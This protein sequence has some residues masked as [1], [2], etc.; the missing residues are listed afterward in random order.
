MTEDRISRICS[1]ENCNRQHNCKGYCRKHY[2]RWQKYGN[3][4]ITLTHVAEGDTLAERF[5]S[6]VE[7]T[8]DNN[9]CWNWKGFPTR[10]WHPSFTY[11]GRKQVV[12]RWAWF[13]TYGNDATMNLLHSCDN[14]RCVNP[15]HLREGTHQENMRDKQ[16]RGRQPKGEAI[17]TAQIV[18][19]DVRDIRLRLQTGIGVSAL[20]RQ[21]NISRDI[22]SDISLGRTWR[23]VT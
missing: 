2:H 23:H 1:V 19:A 5:W 17:H 4:L 10:R 8:S 22:V 16:E 9:R 7:L 12:S 6:M 18:E 13:L 14:P 3:P 20:A 21:M 15:K 11:Q